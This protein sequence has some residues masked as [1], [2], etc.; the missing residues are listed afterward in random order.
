M[1]SLR[2]RIN[3]AVNQHTDVFLL[4][5]AVVVLFLAVTVFLWS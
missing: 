1:S 5:T 3:D 4:G 2:D